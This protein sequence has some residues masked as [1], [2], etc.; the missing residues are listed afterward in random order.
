MFRFCSVLFTRRSVEGMIKNAFSFTCFFIKPF[1]ANLQPTSFVHECSMCLHEIPKLTFLLDLARVTTKRKSLS[2]YSHTLLTALIKHLCV[3]KLHR[4][5]LCSL[6]VCCHNGQ[7]GRKQ[8]FCTGGYNWWGSLWQCRKLMSQN[9]DSSCWEI[10]QQ[11][12]KSPAWHLQHQTNADWV[13][14]RHQRE[15][16]MSLLYFNTNSFSWT[17]IS[18]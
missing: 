6:G 7:V 15:E 2:K 9:H 4:S 17:C 11:K 10:T 1:P 18:A 3:A 8:L 13:K 12:K 16:L 5:R 14:M